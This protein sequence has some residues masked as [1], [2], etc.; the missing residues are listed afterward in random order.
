MTPIPNE[1]AEPKRDDSP[2]TQERCEKVVRVQ[3]RRIK[4]AIKQAEEQMQITEAYD[5]LTIAGKALANMKGD[6][7]M[8]LATSEA[9]GHVSKAR[10]AL[11]PYLATVPYAME[12]K[13]Q[14]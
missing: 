14:P 5:L 3:N 12:K 8:T 2:L 13:E 7:R 1:Q 11:A 4:R 9:H 10:L 6:A